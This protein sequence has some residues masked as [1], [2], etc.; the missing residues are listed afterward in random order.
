MDGERLFFLRENK[1]LTQNQLGQVLGVSKYAISKWENGKETIPLSKL[2]AYANYF[3]VSMDYILKISTISKNSSI[4]SKVINN[5]TINN[6][7]IDKKIIGK[8]IKTI[9]IKNNLTQRDLAKIL[10]TT[11]SAIWAYEK[12]K[13]TI[14]TSFAYQICKRYNI[15]M[16]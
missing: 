11:H 10:N 6:K 12:G 16:D 1:D 14:L 7:E 15:S 8:N 13:A 5:S 2:N 3:N 9:R 4:N